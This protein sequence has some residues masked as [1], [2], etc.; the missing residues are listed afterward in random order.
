MKSSCVFAESDLWQHLDGLTKPPRSLGQLER[1]AARLGAIQQTLSPLT[2]PRRLVLFVADHGVVAEGVSAWPVEVTGQMIDNIL[3]G[4]AASSVLAK[5]SETQLKLVDAGALSG[6]SEID[7]ASTTIAYRQARI[8]AGSRNLYHE[9]ALTVDE[10]EAALQV[11]RDEAAFALEDGITVVGCGEMGIGNTTSA[12]CLTMLLAD[13]PWQQAV[14]RGAGAGDEVF[15]TKQHVVRS[16]AERARRAEAARSCRLI[17]SVAGLEIAA[18]AGF[19]L[20]AHETGMTI[21][22]DGYVTTAAALIA[23]T[24]APGCAGSM[25]ASHLSAEPGHRRALQTLGLSPFLEWDLRLGEGTGALLLMPLLD[26]AAAICS[27]MSTLG[28][29]GIAISDAGRTPE[30]DR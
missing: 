18:M 6:G 12:A 13:V 14:G 21:L 4:G 25:I 5:A 24:L 1:L 27:Q 26:A 28:E 29:M 23:E 17:A 8:R 16:A 15:F 9:P 7:G 22:L 3:A 2:K 19:F 11:G 10:F 20:A 30:A